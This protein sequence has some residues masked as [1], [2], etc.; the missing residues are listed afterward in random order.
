MATNVADGVLGGG[1]FGG[2]D[3]LFPGAGVLR[4]LTSR[5]RAEEPARV[6]LLRPAPPP[7]VDS[8]S[9]ASF[10]REHESVLRAAALRLCGNATDANDLVQDT[11]ERGLRSLARFQ[12]GTDGRA[13]L[14][15]ILHNLFIDRCRARTRESRADTSAEE[16]AERLPA[17]E[18]EPQPSWASIS[19]EQLRAALAKLPEDFQVV[20]RMH[21]LESRSYQEIAE[22]LGI[23][24][25]TVGTRLIRARR[26]LKE[27]LMPTTGES[28]G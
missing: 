28:Q 13:W 18:A 19:T 5:R 15:T 2:G 4:A 17:P 16:L 1:G 14:L 20:Y 12:P 22:T 8:R 6:E 3:A 23:P 10:A 11:F 21:A 7:P 25:A 9:F 27:L 26:K 24:K